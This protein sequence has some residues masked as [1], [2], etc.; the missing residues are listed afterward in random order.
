MVLLIALILFTKRVARTK[1]S[2]T[3]WKLSLL[4][5]T[6]YWHF[7][8]LKEILVVGVDKKNI[9]DLKAIPNIEFIKTVQTKFSEY[10]PQPVK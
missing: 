8:M 2:V 7:G 1:F 3:L 4:L 9:D 5:I 6:F 10:K